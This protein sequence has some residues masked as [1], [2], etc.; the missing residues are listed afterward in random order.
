[1]TLANETIREL[2]P[3]NM[4]DLARLRTQQLILKKQEFSHLDDPVRWI[5]TNFFVPELK[6]PIVLEPYH[7]GVL[8]EALSKDE[9]GNYRY[10]TIVWS[11]IKKSIKSCIAAAVA[12]YVCFKTEWG[13]VILVAN[14]LKGAD[15]RVG[16]YMRRAIEMNP[17]LSSLC[18][19]R[20]YRI[21]FPNHS[22]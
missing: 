8:R 20:N 11:D 18:R 3:T 15:S 4:V 9:A 19:I 2:S 16:Y 1:M 21:E 13:Q 14:D 5:Q 17:A 10:S 6:G 7:Q 12:L 22:Y